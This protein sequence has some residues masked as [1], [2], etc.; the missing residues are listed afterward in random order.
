[1]HSAWIQSKKQY[2]THWLPQPMD[3]HNLP[4]GAWADNW[5]MILKNDTIRTERVINKAPNKET[6]GI[7][8]EE[9][10]S[11]L[12]GTSFWEHIVGSCP[13]EQF[14]RKYSATLNAM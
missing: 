5:A 7:F 10:K 2:V 4:K 3:S 9:A 6:K 12:K 13:L 1:M 14:Y 8:Q 11:L